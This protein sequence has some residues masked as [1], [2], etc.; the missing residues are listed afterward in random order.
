MDND[1]IDRGRTDV[2]INFNDKSYKI[3]L[4]KALNGSADMLQALFRRD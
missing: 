3:P 2:K 1:E 4:S